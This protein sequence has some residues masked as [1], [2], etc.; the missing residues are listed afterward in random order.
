MY[1]YVCVCV[2][3]RE[4]ERER[5]RGRETE[6]QRDRD[7]ETERPLQLTIKHLCQAMCA[8]K[9]NVRKYHDSLET[10]LVF[11]SLVTCCYPNLHKNLCRH[12]QQ[13]PW[14]WKHLESC[15]PHLLLL[16]PSV[17]LGCCFWINQLLLWLQDVSELCSG[18]LG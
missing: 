2:C 17:M 3:E 7:R 1:V 12:H 8:G 10:F 6:R 9:K 16:K 13:C 15:L 11:S 18:L 14:Q 5:E 4:R